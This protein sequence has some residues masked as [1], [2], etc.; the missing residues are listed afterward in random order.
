MFQALCP[1]STPT[2]HYYRS[3]PVVLHA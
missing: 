3:Q 1:S 2:H